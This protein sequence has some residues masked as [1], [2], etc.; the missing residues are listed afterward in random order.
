MRP[1]WQNS[2]EAFL[3]DAVYLRKRFKSTL[4]NG[5]TPAPVH[6]DHFADIFLRQA[7]VLMPI[8]YPALAQ[9]YHCDVNFFAV[10]FTR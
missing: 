3:I 8:I 2:E 1:I 4:V 7:A 10:L 6:S 5:Q 9:I